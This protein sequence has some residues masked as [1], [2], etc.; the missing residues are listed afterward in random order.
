MNDY[1]DVGGRSERAKRAR[2]LLIIIFKLPKVT[3]APVF[4]AL[5]SLGKSQK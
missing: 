2:S 5:Y 1:D 4:F 3:N